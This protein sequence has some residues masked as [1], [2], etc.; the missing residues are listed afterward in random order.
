MTNTSN[1]KYNY[2]HIGLLSGA[3]LKLLGKAHTLD[4][5]R[6]LSNSDDGVHYKEI[7]EMFNF[8]GVNPR[9]KELVKFGCVSQD[10]SKTYHI[11]N[12]G[13]ELLQ[14]GEKI[15]RVRNPGETLE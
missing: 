4:I 3:E 11:T 1:I 7:F 13:R 9:L 5:L 14:L 6:I 15:V 10:P 8:S 12:L 2:Q